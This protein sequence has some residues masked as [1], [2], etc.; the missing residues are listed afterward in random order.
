MGS[1]T[2]S[3]VTISAS[4]AD[5][6]A[7]IA[8]FARYPRWAAALR[9]AEVVEPGEDGRARRV[10]FKLDAGLVRDTYVL[11]YTWHDDVAVSWRLAEPG[12]MISEMTG[13]YLLA[14]HDAGT[15]V[16]YELTVDVRV[17]MPGLVK[18]RAE[19]MIVDTALKGLKARVEALGDGESP[20]GAR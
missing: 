1:K 20:G 2:A 13:E 11:G 8:D 6:M 10:R 17:P 18:R 12:S 4:R 15:E 14:D 9:S 5:V 19:K 7:V 16:N 3:S